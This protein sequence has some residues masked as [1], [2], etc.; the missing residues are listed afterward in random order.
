MLKLK[1]NNRKV[2]V[3][4]HHKSSQEKIGDLDF[5]I[6]DT[7]QAACVLTWKYFYGDSEIPW[8]LRYVQDR[9]IWTWEYG[10]NTNY[11]T[12]ALYNREFNFRDWDYYLDGK[13]LNVLKLQGEILARAKNKRVYNYVKAWEKSKQLWILEGHRIPILNLPKDV[14][15]HALNILAKDWYVACS[16]H[17]TPDGYRNFELRSVDPKFDVSLIAQRFGGGGHACA[18]G[19]RLKID[20]FGLFSDNEKP[21]QLEIKRL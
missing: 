4:D 14:A 3:I 10:E 20:Q 8:L 21:V 5:V 2:I 12:E 17:D 1:K 18:S 9:D 13:N 6:M 15:S 7:E 19:F 16:Y 11:I